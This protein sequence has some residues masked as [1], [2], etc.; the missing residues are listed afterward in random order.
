M[1]ERKPDAPNVPDV[2]NEHH[3]NTTPTPTNNHLPPDFKS[4]WVVKQIDSL[5]NIIHR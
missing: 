2:P 4:S 1:P 5:G 3:E